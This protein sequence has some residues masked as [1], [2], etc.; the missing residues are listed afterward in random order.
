[1]PKLI[2]VLCGHEEDVSLVHHLNTKHPQ[3]KLA[4]YLLFMPFQ[5]VVNREFFAA[6][7]KSVYQGIEDNSIKELKAISHEDRL[8]IVQTAETQKPQRSCIIVEE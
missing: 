6:I 2:C 1:M 7:K 3:G 4:A 5:K 8:S